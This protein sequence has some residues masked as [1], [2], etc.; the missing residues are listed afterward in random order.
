[1]TM[2]ATDTPPSLPQ[3]WLARTEAWLDDMP[4]DFDVLSLLDAGRG[5]G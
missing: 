2:Y 3:G 1:M 5:G 4:D